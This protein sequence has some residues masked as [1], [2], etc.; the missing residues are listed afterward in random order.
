MVDPKS[1]PALI[2]QNSLNTLTS[3]PG[4][5]HQQQH[6]YG[7]VFSINE[8]DTEDKTIAKLKRLTPDYVYTQYEILQ[9]YGTFWF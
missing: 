6:H 8:K 7:P 3:G 9:F 4:Y 2:E 1:V 5:H